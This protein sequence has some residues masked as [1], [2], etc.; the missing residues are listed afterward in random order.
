MTELSELLGLLNKS[1]ITGIILTGLSLFSCYLFIKNIAYLLWVTRSFDHDR[2]RET[3]QECNNPLQAVIQSAL[4]ARV[5][6]GP[7]LKTELAYLFH[8]HF[9]G[10]E[11]DIALLRLGAAIAPLLGLMGTAL[12]MVKVFRVIATHT[13]VNPALLAGGIW[14]A[15]ITTIM[16]LAIGIPTMCFFYVLV[17]RMQHLRIVAIEHSCL[18]VSRKSRSRSPENSGDCCVSRSAVCRTGELGI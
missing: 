3:D 15:L 7:D 1:G 18:A 4:H 17:L 6:C 2:I 14:E 13:S 8:R 16:G 10:V 9:V 5:P 12:G 11:R